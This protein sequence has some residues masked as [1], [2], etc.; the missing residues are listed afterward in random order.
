MNALGWYI[1]PALRFKNSKENIHLS[2][3]YSNVEWV[4]PFLADLN[5]C[6]EKVKTMKS[7]DFASVIKKEIEKIDPADL[8]DNDVSQLLGM[9]GVSDGALPKRMAEINE[10]LNALPSNLRE[11]LLIGFINDL[12]NIKLAKDI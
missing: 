12:F 2:I 3:N 6:V 10:I 5:L 11:R 8:T 9:A 1:Q 4:E 7:G